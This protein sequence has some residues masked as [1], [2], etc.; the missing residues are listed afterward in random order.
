M[1]IDQKKKNQKKK[2][3][4]KPTLPSP[5]KGKGKPRKTKT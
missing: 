1:G 5:Q 2:T 4:E 3:Q